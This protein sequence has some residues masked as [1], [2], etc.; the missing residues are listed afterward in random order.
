MNK[1]LVWTQNLT[2]VMI[3]RCQN[4]DFV[5][6]VMWSLKLTSLS[7]ITPRYFTWVD[8]KNLGV[9]MDFRWALKIY[10]SFVYPNKTTSTSVRALG[11]SEC[12]LHCYDYDRV[13]LILVTPKC[14]A[15]SISGITHSIQ[16]HRLELFTPLLL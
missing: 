16:I 14:M 11:R 5:I 2:L 7:I 9:F 15:P 13:L 3:S 8:V 10:F 4:S 1:F 6:A 12:H